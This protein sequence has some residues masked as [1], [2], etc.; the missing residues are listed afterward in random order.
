MLEGIKKYTE[1][2]KSWIP[3]LKFWV[4]VIVCVVVALFAYRSW[5]E[6]KAAKSVKEATLAQELRERNVALDKAQVDLVKVIKTNETTLTKLQK[7]W[8]KDHNLNIAQYQTLLLLYEKQVSGQGTSTTPVKPDSIIIVDNQVV[9]H[10]KL[11]YNDFRI[12]IEADVRNSTFDYTLHQRF[13][14]N[15]TRAI[16][17]RGNSAYFANVSELDNTGKSVGEVSVKEFNIKEVKPSAQKFRWFGAP[18]QLGIGA[19]GVD[20]EITPQIFGAYPFLT[21]GYTTVDTT[22][23]IG[24][25][26]GTDGDIHSGGL[27]TGYDIG[28]AIG[29]NL[30]RG[31]K[32]GIFGGI[33]TEGYIMGVG[34]SK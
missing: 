2:L 24:P 1:I 33:S 32:I 29:I 7:D 4:P 6:Y 20:G 34:I 27:W 19:A 18:L 8:M 10:W 21:Y 26:I 28:T 9:K 17:E 3:V 5:T 31:T 23:A 12:N 25:Y 11:N 15:V 22:W 30:L 14:V 13:N 16:D